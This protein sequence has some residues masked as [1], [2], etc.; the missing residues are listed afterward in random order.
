M[1]GMKGREGRGKGNSERGE[2]RGKMIA[3]KGKGMMKMGE[4]KWWGEYWGEGRKGGQML[5]RIL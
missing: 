1:D 5:G 2:G 3:G 4:E